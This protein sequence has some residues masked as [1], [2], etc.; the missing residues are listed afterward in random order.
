M[1]FQVAATNMT[2][3]CKLCS[4]SF[5]TRT[6][7]F[8]HCRLQH[9]H[10]SKTS[11]LPCLHD[12]CMCTFQTL[13]ALSTHLS[14][15]HT[16]EHNSSA[17]E[18]Q[19][20]VT[21]K[22]PL[23]T[24]QQPF[25]ESVLLSHIRTHL[26]K[27][28]TVVCPYKGC[29]YSTNVYSSFNTHKSRVHQASLASDFGSD[30]VYEHTQ[31]LQATSS[32]VT[33]DLDEECP[34]QSTEMQDDT[35]KLKDQLK[36][37][38][39]SLFLKMQTILHVSNTATQEIVDHLNQIFSL[40]QPLIKDAI[41]DVLQG[42]GHNI[43]DSTLDEV[44]SAVMDSNVVFSATSKGAEL[45]SCKRRKTFIERNY[46]L[47]MPV[48]YHLEAPG[49]TMMYVPILQMI[50]ELFK[51]TDILSKIRE[52]N[53]EPGYYVS[54]RDGSHFQENEL[55]STEDLHLAIQLYIDDL[56]IANPLGTS[57]KVHKL[58]A[59]YWVLANVP[60]K[61]RSAMHTIQLAMLAKV[62]DLKKY[63]YAAVLAP[64]VRDIHT[65]EQDG[66]FIESVGQNVKGTIFCVSADNLAAHG[67][68]G[69][70]ESIRAGYVCRF[71]MAT[72]EQFKQLR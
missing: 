13:S 58:C 55:L 25:S 1:C 52:P 17:K 46:P 4:A 23:C 9:S 72:S 35:S 38:A 22:C 20:L 61:Y 6:Y 34:V 33:I 39:A 42:H 68:G 45:S 56:E 44:V 30:I 47:V 26:K 49:H 64:L 48:E 57:R 16:Q 10:F 69:F 3:H 53:T 67:L 62:T 40:S 54:Y 37:N 60:P 41:N 43:T 27:H 15:Y 5:T 36:L 28:E 63:G 51:N 66:V 7:L 2:W 12:D 65:L 21:F 29:N 31:N 32:N 59:V 11:P 70:L 8:K 14:R 50:Q 71:C 19:E 18:I 24:F